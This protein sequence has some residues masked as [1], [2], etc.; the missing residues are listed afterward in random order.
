MDVVTK[1]EAPNNTTS[2]SQ[3]QHSISTKRFNDAQSPGKGSERAFGLHLSIVETG[4]IQRYVL[5]LDRMNADNNV[6]NN[7]YSYL[8]NTS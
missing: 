5:H 6:K 2:E 1:E 4:W 3:P 8:F 7:C